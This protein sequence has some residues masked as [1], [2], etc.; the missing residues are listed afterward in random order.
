VPN[1]SSITKNK[2]TLAAETAI[3]S[4]PSISEQ[5]RFEERPKTHR[6]SSISEASKEEF[7]F[8][9]RS[10]AIP[11]EDEGDESVPCVP[12]SEAKDG[13]TS[14][15]EGKPELADVTRLDK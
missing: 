12:P 11:E 7:E 15:Q 1:T 13:P 6:G 10:E 2:T 14:T 3:E 8:V 9:E 5:R 4:T